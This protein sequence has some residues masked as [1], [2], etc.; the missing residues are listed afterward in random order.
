MVQTTYPKSHLTKA[1]TASKK[2]LGVRHNFN[3]KSKTDSVSNRRK[4]RITKKPYNRS[5][6]GVALDI[7]LGVN[8]DEV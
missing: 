8:P 6:L 3:F 4:N 5:F 1:S 7:M 2:K